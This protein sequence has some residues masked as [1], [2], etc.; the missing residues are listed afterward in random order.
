MSRFV[1]ALPDSLPDLHHPLLGS[2]T[3]NAAMIRGGRAPNVV[4]DECVLTIDRRTLPGET[5]EDVRA[6]FERLLD[7]L[8]R[9]F[10]GFDLAF[11]FAELTQA[12]EIPA[13]AAIAAAVRAAAREERG[14][15]PPDIGFTGITDARFYVNGANTPAVVFGPGDLRVAHTSNEHV[16]VGELI[17]AA[18]IYA[19][20]FV[21]FLGT[22]ATASAPP[23]GR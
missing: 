8:R 21:G 6:P 13:D 5:L 12:A 1:L 19:R 18:R 2:P 23:P 22:S 4:P 15:E 10:S 11:E 3:V 17:E 9:E 16:A 20:S 14:Q 7:R